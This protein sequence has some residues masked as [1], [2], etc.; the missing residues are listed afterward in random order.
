MHYR[1]VHED[2]LAAFPGVSQ[3][4]QRLLDD[5]ENY[6]GEPPG[7]YIVFSDTFGTMVEVALAS[8]ETTPGREDVLRRACDFGEA[9][10]TASDA[11]VHDL[12]IDALAER[13]DNRQGGPA[14]AEHLGGPSLRAW[15]SAHS[16]SDRWRGDAARRR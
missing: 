12:C 1:T 10:L 14:V 16:S 13:L 9:M 4:Y 11:A 7:Q 5:W 3:P 2:L 8:P 6:G 15:F